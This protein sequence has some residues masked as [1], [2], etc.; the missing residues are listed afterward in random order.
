MLVLVGCC[1]YTQLFYPGV[2]HR[3]PGDT[4]APWFNLY[5]VRLL[6][7]L[8][9]VVPV[10]VL[11]ASA[12]LALLPVAVFRSL[13]PEHALHGNFY[14]PLF[15]F[16]NGRLGTDRLLV[17]SAAAPTSTSTTST[18][19]T[20]ISAQRFGAVDRA[21]RMRTANRFLA[22]ARTGP[23][24]GG[25]DHALRQAHRLLTLKRSTGASASAASATR[26]STSTSTST[27]TNTSTNTSTHPGVK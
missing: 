6:A 20:T 18:T 26:K 2:Y 24:E 19:S 7:W 8:L 21:L 15:Q 23:A 3:E 27:S 16:L 9:A 10:T 13:D 25:L 14:R 22:A 17:A 11:Y 4:E 5:L 12:K 1:T